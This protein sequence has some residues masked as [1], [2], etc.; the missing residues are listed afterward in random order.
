MAK[1]PHL[2]AQNKTD[3]PDQQDF[4]LPKKAGGLYIAGF[5]KHS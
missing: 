4:K 5:T 3:I 1:G 2:S